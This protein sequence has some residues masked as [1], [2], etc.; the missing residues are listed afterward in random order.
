MDDRPTAPCM[1][2]RQARMPRPPRRAA[3][4]VD[5]SCCLLRCACGALALPAGTAKALGRLR[6]CVLSAA[7]QRVLRRIAR[8]LAGRAN[9]CRRAAPRACKVPAEPADQ[10]HAAFVAMALHELRNPLAPIRQVAQII[11]RHPSGDP[12]LVWCRDVIERQVLQ[13]L[14]LLDDLQ[15]FSRPSRQPMA[16]RCE[17]LDLR[18]AIAQALETAGPLLSEQRHRLVVEQPAQPV[19]VLGDL[20]RLTQVFGNLLGNAAK[21]T[22]AG[23]HIVVS[24]RQAPRHAEV[25][26]QD[27]GIGIEP[28]Q[29]ERVFGLFVQLASAPHQAAGGHGIGLAVI[30]LL[31]EQHGGEVA[32]TSDG[33]GRGSRFTVRLPLAP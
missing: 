6:G 29:L 15:D 30:R 25:V 8:R 31:V 9:R 32:A 27:D 10:T 5:R 24:V 16:M 26:V 11:G 14:R 12:T 2:P 21:Y 3:G 19:A 1:L 7:E 22:P 20:A 4:D 23:G 33:M 17:R 28:A 18:L 13:M